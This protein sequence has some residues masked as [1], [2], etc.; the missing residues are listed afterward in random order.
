MSPD[1]SITRG[2]KLAEGITK[3]S[4][5]LQKPSV[6]YAWC[7]TLW[8]NSAITYGRS[9]NSTYIFPDQEELGNIYI[10]QSLETETTNICKSINENLI[11][12]FI[13]GICHEHI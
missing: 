1:C 3:L 6:K 5:E 13:I 9:K 11:A 12:N 8:Q 4:D 7:T 2:V 10:F